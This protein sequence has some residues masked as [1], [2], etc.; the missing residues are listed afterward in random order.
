MEQK[1][2]D[3]FDAEETVVPGASYDINKALNL[4]LKAF[5]ISK[6]RSVTL[7]KLYQALC[8]IPATSV[9]SERAFSAVGL[10]VTKLRSNLGDKSIDSL[11]FLR[12]HFKKEE[13]EKKE[14]EQQ[15][16]KK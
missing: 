16:A 15:N 5:E 2:N 6:K 14:K 9:E 4:E 12:S 13:R 3:I 8:S 1:F 10:F 11:L 7:E